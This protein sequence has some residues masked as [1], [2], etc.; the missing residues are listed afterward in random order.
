[1]LHLDLGPWAHLFHTLHEQNF[2]AH[3]IG[4]A[5]KIGPYKSRGNNPGVSLALLL[6]LISVCKLV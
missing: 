5:A 4:H 3:V 2:V 6:A 1:M